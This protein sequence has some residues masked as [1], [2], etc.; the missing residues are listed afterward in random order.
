[1][2]AAGVRA[3]LVHKDC[4][5]FVPRA[6]YDLI[7]SNLPFGN[8]V[9]THQDNERL[10]ARLCTMLPE[11]LAPGGVAVL[12]TMEYTLLHRCLGAQKKLRRVG[13]TRTAAGGLLPWVIVVERA[14]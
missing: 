11:W 13:E 12:Y 9:G 4:T 6:P 5:A 8:R 7:L 14:E 10:Y 3:G 1:M 2:R